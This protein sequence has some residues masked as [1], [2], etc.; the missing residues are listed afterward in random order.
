MVWVS[1]IAPRVCTRYFL[2]LCNLECMLYDDCGI[3]YA[4]AIVCVW[5]CWYILQWGRFVFNFHNDEYDDVDEAGLLLL[6]VRVEYGD[7][8][9]ECWRDDSAPVLWWWCSI[10]EYIQYIC[11]WLYKYEIKLINI[12]HRLSKYMKNICMIRVYWIYSYL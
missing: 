9:V 1:W 12:Y 8:D 3:G 5:L 6:C 4:Y 10:L 11:I 2:F 7:G